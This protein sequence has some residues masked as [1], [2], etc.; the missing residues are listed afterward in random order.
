[1]NKATNKNNDEHYRVRIFWMMVSLLESTG[2]ESCNT[3]EA[4][5]DR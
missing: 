3:K 2:N 1:M 4:T 5:N